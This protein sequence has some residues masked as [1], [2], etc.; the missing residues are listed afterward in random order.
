[1]QVE[2]FVVRFGVI[3]LSLLGVALISV[4]PLTR[5]ST[6]RDY[7]DLARTQEPLLRVPLEQ[8]RAT[9]EGAFDVTVPTDVQWKRVASRRGPAA[10]LIVAANNRNEAGS[11][12]YAL[13]QFGLSLR[14]LRNGSDARPMPTSETPYGYSAFTPNNGLVF[15]AAPGDRIHL[16]VR[17]LSHSPVPTHSVLLMVPSWSSWNVGEDTAFG[18][19]FSHIRALA[20]V[21]AGL[22]CLLAATAVGLSRPAA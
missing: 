11:Q 16:E 12:T 21:V 15:T 20:A 8:F 10:L 19:A 5:I 1:V 6:T 14:V 9:G 22:V 13:S 3:G 4:Y 2:K 7:A 18:A 17:L